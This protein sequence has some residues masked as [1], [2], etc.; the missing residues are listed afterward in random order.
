VL[1]NRLTL[2]EFVSFTFYINLLVWPMIATGWVWNMVQRGFA[3]AKRVLEL[4]D[5]AP[6][7][8]VTATEGSPTEPLRGNIEFRDLSFRYAP[9]SGAMLKN[10]SLTIPAGSSVGIIGK[11]GAGKT[12]LVSL[13]FHLYPV[14]TGRLFIDGRDINDIPLARLRRSISYVPQDSFL[15]SGSI[16]ENIAFALEKDYDASRLTIEAAAAA[17]GIHGDIMEF[18]HGYD[19]LIGERGIMLSGGQK[20][21]VAIARA[22][23]VA[24]APILIL[25]DALS[26]VDVVTES[27]ILKN[28]HS[29]IAL[30]TSFIIAHRIST[31]KQCDT[32][33]VLDGGHISE[34]GTHDELVDKGG[35]YATLWKLQRL[36]GPAS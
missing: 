5:T 8:T 29:V 10:I 35:F 7:V 28:L 3:S 22:L 14:E 1:A 34:A 26:A 27:A 25:D 12:T 2:G 18:P 16:L 24:D 32:I 6:D 23:M 21:R 31:V 30:K 17:A 13:L 33:I 4:L 36:R 9:D 15:F 20:Q 11:P 19:T